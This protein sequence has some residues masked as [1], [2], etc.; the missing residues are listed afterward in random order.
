MC[1]VH[2]KSHGS[3]PFHRRP[4]DELSLLFLSLS[5]LLLVSRWSLLETTTGTYFFTAVTAAAAAASSGSSSTLAMVSAE[6]V[7]LIFSNAF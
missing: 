6:L 7:V 1:A 5:L 4:S 2:P 3:H